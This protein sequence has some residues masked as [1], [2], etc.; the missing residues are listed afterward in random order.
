[1]LTYSKMDHWPHAGTMRVT[2][3][4]VGLPVDANMIM[5]SCDSARETDSTQSDMAMAWRCVSR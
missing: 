4:H 3:K 1:M 2:T 5:I